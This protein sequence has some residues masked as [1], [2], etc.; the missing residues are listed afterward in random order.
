MILA[1]LM[2]KVYQHVGR[3]MFED[4]RIL[5]C[6]NEGQEEISRIVTAPTMEVI[7]KN[8]TGAFKPKVILADGTVVDVDYNGI[9]E[10]YASRGRTESGAEN[11]GEGFPYGGYRVDLRTTS[12]AS[13]YFPN[14]RENMRYGTGAGG[15][16]WES[17]RPIQY[18]IYDPV[19]LTAELTPLP[20]PVRATD[21]YLKL[22]VRPTPMTE[23]DD[24][25]LNGEFASFHEAVW[26]YAVFL[27]VNEMAG[28]EAQM[29]GMFHYNRFK[30]LTDRM[31]SAA[32]PE[33]AFITKE[34]SEFGDW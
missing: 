8:V 17:G 12:D 30:Q 25:P 21:L 14:W 4:A 26:K 3:S 16:T 19:N 20:K 33:P 11:N 9:L 10:V 7:Q 32:R 2:E 13:R 6:L 1:E 5:E 23:R 27:L 28:E 24:V 18:L 22:H 15:A 34:T 31:I 29:R